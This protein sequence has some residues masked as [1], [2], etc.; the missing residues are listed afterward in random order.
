MATEKDLAGLA[1]DIAKLAKSM[2]TQATALA[3]FAAGGAGVSGG[4]DHSLALGS[5]YFIRAVTHY[6]IGRLVAITRNDLTLEG[7]SWVADAGRWSECLHD[8]KVQEI[9]HYPGKGITFVNRAAI[10]DVAPWGH[11]L[12][13][14]EAAKGTP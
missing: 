10:V 14:E 9:E 13:Q 7:A 1:A 11:P 3:A 6:Y 2:E 5:T 4:I 8:G 12:P